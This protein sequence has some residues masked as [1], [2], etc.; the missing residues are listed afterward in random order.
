[1]PIDP[2]LIAPLPLPIPRSA[3]QVAQDISASHDSVA[4]INQIVGDDQRSDDIDDTMQRNVRH[5]RDCLLLPHIVQTATDADKAA[6]AAAVA[7]GDGW[8]LP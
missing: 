7:I 6:F 2:T 1:M 4:L 8:L 3:E 5:L